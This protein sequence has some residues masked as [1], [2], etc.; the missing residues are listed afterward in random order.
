LE[1]NKNPLA[2]GSVDRRGIQLIMFAQVGIA[3]ISLNMSFFGF[4]LVLLNILLFTAYSGGIRLKERVVLDIFTHGLM[5]GAVPFLAGFILCNGNI[6]PE[7]LLMTLLLFILGGEALMAHQVIEYE[8]DLK[9]T[10]TTVIVIGQR[11]GLLILGFLAVISEVLL[12]FVASTKLLPFWVLAA[13][14]WYL[15]AY[16]AYSCRSIF[17]DFRHIASPE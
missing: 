3:M 6:Y 5:F 17:H 15:I 12:F 2:S 8:E 4:C 10:R 9:S 16:P 7:T 11:N 14:S 13:L 1:S